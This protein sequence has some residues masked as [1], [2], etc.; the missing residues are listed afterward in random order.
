MKRGYKNINKTNNRKESD[1]DY[2]RMG[3]KMFDK[4]GYKIEKKHNI[5]EKVISDQPHHH[6]QNFPVIFHLL[7]IVDFLM[8]NL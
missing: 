5:K 8:Q 4:K 2:H 7:G 3:F 6:K 1:F